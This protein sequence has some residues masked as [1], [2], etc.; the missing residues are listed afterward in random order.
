[1]PISF[2]AII[3]VQHHP[4]RAELLDRLLPALAPLPVEVIADPE[5][6]GK[7]SAWRTYRECLARPTGADWIVVVQD[8]AIPA[9]GFADALPTILA[10]NAGALVC[11]FTAGAPVRLAHRVREAHG[12]GV[13]YA[14]HGWLDWTPTVA[15]A[16]PAGQARRMVEWADRKGIP[17]DAQGDDNLVG[18]FVTSTRAECVLTAPCVVQHPDDAPSL[19]GRKSRGGRNPFRVAAVW[20][21]SADYDWTRQQINT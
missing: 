9:A 4:S 16:W 1:M 6:E 11:L 17:G 7:R 3:R 21:G 19:I 5:P 2:P 10:A 18:K 15:T 8:D 13:R 14:R 20:T 12:R